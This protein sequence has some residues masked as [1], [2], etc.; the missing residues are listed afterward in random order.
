MAFRTTLRLGESRAPT[1][2]LCPGYVASPTSVPRSP[3]PHRRVSPPQ[4]FESRQA[5]QTLLY[6][7]RAVYGEHR[8][9]QFTEI[10]VYTYPILSYP[11]LAVFTS[12]L[13]RLAHWTCMDVP[14]RAT[15]SPIFH[16]SISTERISLRNLCHT[17]RISGRSET[18][19]SVKS[20]PEA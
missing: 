1:P 7:H 3:P 16:Q 8:G 12:L 6:V 15:T 4:V 19:T 5:P 20:R 10:T 13:Y 17:D 14:M 2:S 11:L 18:E 9:L